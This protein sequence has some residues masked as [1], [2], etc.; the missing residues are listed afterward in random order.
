MNFKNKAPETKFTTVFLVLWIVLGV[1]ILISGMSAPLRHGGMGFVHSIP[2]GLFG[3]FILYIGI[4]YMTFHIKARDLLYTVC[5]N[6]SVQTANTY[7]AHHRQHRP[8]FY[9]EINHPNNWNKLRDY[10]Y[11]LNGSNKIPTNLKSEILD[12]LRKDGLHV[13]TTVIDNYNG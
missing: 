11:K 1:Y 9:H 12:T 4:R 10:W 8:I 2:F 13:N 6:P 7:L 3:I 5:Q